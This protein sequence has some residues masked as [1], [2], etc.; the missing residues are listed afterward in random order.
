MWLARSVKRVYANGLNMGA[1]C[2]ASPAP[3]GTGSED[4]TTSDTCKCLSQEELGSFF[5]GHEGGRGLSWAIDA[6]NEHG[7]MTVT[8]TRLI[9]M[10]PDSVPAE[11]PAF[12]GTF[13]V[14]FDCKGAAEE[15]RSCFVDAG[16]GVEAPIPS[17]LTD[18]MKPV[19]DTEMEVAITRADNL[20]NADV[21]SLSD[22]Y[23]SVSFQTD[24]GPPGR[25]ARYTSV[26][27]NNLSPVWNF[28]LPMKGYQRGDDLR[29]EVFD[30]DVF[31]KQDDK[32]GG[33]KLT[34][35]QFFPWG[36]S[37]PPVPLGGEGAG[38]SK[39]TVTVKVGAARNVLLS[40]AICVSVN[41]QCDVDA[42]TLS[43]TASGATDACN[44][45]AAISLGRVATTVAEDV[46]AG[47]VR[48]HL[49]NKG[50]VFKIAEGRATHMRK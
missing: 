48:E 6:N 10:S 13:F 32:L 49:R 19:V 25:N 37:G 40:L 50:V 3:P 12:E 36:Y 33:A 38:K 5:G 41:F 45:T 35:E 22:P 8:V 7:E 14:T 1:L 21:A 26:V 16:N 34:S 15:F 29:M 27:Q 42:G 28:S 47:A 44:E 4:I 30:K 23:C 20:R 24:G 31:P 46:L 2:P 39:A 11:N 9:R 17:W 18:S 43:A